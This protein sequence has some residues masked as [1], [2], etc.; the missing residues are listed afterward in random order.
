MVGAKGAIGA[1]VFGAIG[2]GG[3]TIVKF[4]L[5]LRRNTAFK[6]SLSSFFFNKTMASASSVV[7]KPATVEEAKLPFDLKQQI[8]FLHLQADIES[9]LQQL[10]ALSRRPIKG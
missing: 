5:E 8:E 9:L 3:W 6:P 10:Q 2:Y 4:A 1:S 7:K